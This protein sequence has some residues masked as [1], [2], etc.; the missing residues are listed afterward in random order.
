ML[1]YRIAF[2]LATF[3]FV[4]IVFWRDFFGR[5]YCVVLFWLM[6]MFC[7]VCGFWFGGGAVLPGFWVWFCFLGLFVFVLDLGGVCVVVFCFVC[8]LLC[9][10][11]VLLFTLF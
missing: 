5:C 6:V 4:G 3:R 1:F 7:F 9:F 11:F 2:G 10:A 8:V